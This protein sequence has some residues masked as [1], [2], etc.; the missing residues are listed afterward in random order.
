MI[1]IYKKYEKI[2]IKVTIVLNFK[3]HFDK[4]KLIIKISINNDKKREKII[5][6]SEKK[7]NNFNS[8]NQTM[9]SGIIGIINFLLQF[10]EIDLCHCMPLINET[11]IAPYRRESSSKRKL[12]FKYILEKK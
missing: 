7:L 9:K 5:K 2:A 10:E 12:K 3:Y 1:K 4:L 6:I 8:Y 11:I